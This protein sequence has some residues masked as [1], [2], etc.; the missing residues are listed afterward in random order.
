MANPFEFLRDWARD[1]VNATVFDDDATANLL[2]AQCLGAAR[3][4]GIGV[5]GV[6]KAAGGNLAGF[7]LSELDSAANTELDRLVSDDKS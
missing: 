7:F 6:I 1:N 3:D 4:A 2:A 5:A